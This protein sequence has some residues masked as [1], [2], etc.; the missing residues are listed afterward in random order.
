MIDIEKLEKVFHDYFDECKKS[1]IN[2]DK[3]KLK[4]FVSSLPSDLFIQ[5]SENNFKVFIKP[6]EK[7]SF[8]DFMINCGFG[9]VNGFYSNAQWIE[10]EEG[11]L[12]NTDLD[13][14]CGFVVKD[15]LKRRYSIDLDSVP[16]ENGIKRIILEKVNEQYYL[17]TIDFIANVLDE[18]ESDSSTNATFD[19]NDLIKG[20][21]LF[22]ILRLKETSDILE[23]TTTRGDIPKI[24]SQIDTNKFEIIYPVHGRVVLKVSSIDSNSYA[25]YKVAGSLFSSLLGDKVDL[26]KMSLSSIRNG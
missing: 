12:F 10:Q 20:R 18:I 11:F 21:S 13:R 16:V 22:N 8:V 17:V 15:G 3:N 24:K 4:D 26:I 5:Q 6:D 1:S 23:L 25:V 9:N 7:D 19:Y 14:L 2:L